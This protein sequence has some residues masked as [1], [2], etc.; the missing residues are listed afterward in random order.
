MPKLMCAITA[1]FAIVLSSCSV[2]VPSDEVVDVAA[3]QQATHDKYVSALNANDLERIM[4]SYSEDIVLQGPGS[5][6]TIGKPAVRERMTTY[7][8][9]YNDEFD[10]TVEQFTVSDD[11]AFSRYTYKSTTKNKKTGA[12]TT[13]DGKGVFIFH[14]EKDGEWRLVIDSWN[15][16]KT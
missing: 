15:S 11:W 9:N 6:E 14:R 8:E 1:A 4:D 12:V 10:K 2:S 7:L 3:A 13:D 5:P 16:D